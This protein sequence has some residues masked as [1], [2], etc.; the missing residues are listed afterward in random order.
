MQICGKVH[1][2]IYPVRVL[3]VNGTIPMMVNLYWHRKQDGG[4]SNSHISGTIK[5]RQRW[6]DLRQVWRQN[7]GGPGGHFQECYFKQIY[8]LA[9]CTTRMF[10]YR[11]IKQFQLTNISLLIRPFLSR[12]KTVLV[13]VGDISSWFRHFINLIPYDTIAYNKIFKVASDYTKATQEQALN[14]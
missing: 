6:H 14:Y 1:C 4:R 2:L 9:M 8:S 12:C 13:L 7:F 11:R 10:T 5:R 3:R